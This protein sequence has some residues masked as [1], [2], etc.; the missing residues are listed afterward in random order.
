MKIAVMQ[1]YL[2]PYIGYWQLMKEVDKFIIF[3]DVNYIQKG[4]INRNNILV[5]NQLFLFTIPIVEASQ[6]KMINELKVVSDYKWKTKLLKTLELAYKKAPHFDVIFPI[7][8]QIIT[9]PHV[10]IKDYI[11]HSFHLINDYL[12]I[13]TAIVESST[14]YNNHHLKASKR[15]IDICLKEKASTYINPLG[16]TDL[17]DKEEFE[18]NNLNLYF[19]K[20]NFI[21][22][23]QFNNDFIPY[24]SIIDILMFNDK[25]NLNYILSQYQL[26]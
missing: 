6:N 24:L 17:Y 16:G 7:I 4:W 21:A 10:F 15:I 2:F 19:I 8:E 5:N 25:D 11:L 22:Y 14:I 9:N 12:S 26:I 20:N 3:D 1:P 23:Q 13:E 18:K